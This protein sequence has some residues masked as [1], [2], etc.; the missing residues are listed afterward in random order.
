MYTNLQPINTVADKNK[1]AICEKNV[2]PLIT[3]HLISLSNI[4][5]M[6]NR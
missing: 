6:G 2:T 1:D 3:V 5:K 4:G